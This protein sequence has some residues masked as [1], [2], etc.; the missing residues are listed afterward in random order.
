MT[1]AQTILKLIETVDP[2]D[3][4]K[5]DE[6]DAR[7]TAFYLRQTY[8][9]YSNT[10]GFDNERCVYTKE[11]GWIKRLELTRS[12]DALK[13]IR[14]E[15][16]FLICNDQNDPEQFRCEFLASHKTLTIYAYAPTEELA[17][18]H[19]IIQAIEYERGRK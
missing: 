4:A 3:T 6:I 10:V 13:A 2:A 5:L 12:R 19:A 11:H 16:Y 14:P 15:G 8:D 18:L 17:E 7:A 9:T 1:D